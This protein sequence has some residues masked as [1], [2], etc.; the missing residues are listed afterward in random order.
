VVADPTATLVVEPST[1]EL[2]RINSPEL[3]VVGPAKVFAPVSSSV[4]D[5]DFVRP[6]VPLLF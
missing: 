5:P 3:S 4:P 6:T 2:A 1:F